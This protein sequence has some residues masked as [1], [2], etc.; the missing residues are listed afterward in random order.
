MRFSADFAWELAAR[1]AGHDI[2]AGVDEVGRGP[3]AGPVVAAAVILDFEDPP[4]G[5]ADSKALN[6][7]ARRRAFAEIMARARAVA[8]ASAPAT[9]VDVHNIR[10]ASLIAMG[11]ALS[12]LALRPHFALVDG[13][14]QPVGA[15]CPAR[16]LINGDALSLSIAAASIVAKV[17]RDAIMANADADFPGYGFAR[18]MGYPT[19]VHRQALEALGPCALHRRSFAPVACLVRSQ[20]TV[21]GIGMPRRSGPPAK[22]A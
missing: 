8:V 16:A 17:T 14:D 7:S 22:R 2:I 5:V 12:A 15:P 21:A 6:A 20:P 18:H 10:A 4:P 1:A 3:L 9:E 19:L 13:R 11:R